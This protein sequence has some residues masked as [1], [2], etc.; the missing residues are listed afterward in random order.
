MECMRQGGS[1]TVTEIARKLLSHDISQVEYYE[2]IT[3]NM[4]GDVLTTK[5]EITEK[6][7]DGRR[8]AGYRIPNC[9]DLS[10]SEIEDLVSICQTKIDDYIERHGD[11]I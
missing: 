3:K 11:R 9:S 10:E 6:I 2:Q 5:N 8:I 4:V 7:K 1:A